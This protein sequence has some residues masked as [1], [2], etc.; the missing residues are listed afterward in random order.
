MREPDITLST[1]DRQIKV[2]EQEAV[3]M[4]NPLQAQSALR[5]LVIWEVKMPQTRK[6][7]RWIDRKSSRVIGRTDK[8]FGQ[9]MQRLARADRAWIKGRARSKCQA[10]PKD[11]APC[12]H[13]PIES[14]SVQESLLVRLAD[15]GHVFEFPRHISTIRNRLLEDPSRSGLDSLAGDR[16]RPRDLGIGI[17]STR[18]LACKRHDSEIFRPIESAGAGSRHPLDH[19]YITD[20]QYFLLAY[21][22]LMMT[23]EELNGI[24]RAAAALGPERGQDKRLYLCQR[25]HMME[26]YSRMNDIKASFDGA[27]V[28]GDYGSLLI[29]PVDQ[30]IQLP[31]GLAA[32]GPFSIEHRGREN[33]VFLTIYPTSNVAENTGTHRHRIIASYM[34]TYADDSKGSIEILDRLIAALRESPSGVEEFLRVTMG[35]MRNAFFSRDYEQ[36]LPEQLRIAIERKV[37]KSVLAYLQRF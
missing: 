7:R 14:H 13:R 32:A 33:D 11:L 19:A 8:D 6:V 25:G 27:Y 12:S 34:R 26:S 28:N 2:G 3:R 23:I 29:T 24:K 16:W 15:D 21:R 20:E 17:A 9:I 30:F 18:L 1:L 4:E 22:I 31:I 35:E 36:R 10:P 37:S 5:H